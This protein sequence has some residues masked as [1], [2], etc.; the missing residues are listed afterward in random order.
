MSYVP[1]YSQSTFTFGEKKNVEDHRKEKLRG[2]KGQLMNYNQYMF[3]KHS[4]FF[5]PFKKR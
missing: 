3:G 4:L 5:C 2:L 1:V